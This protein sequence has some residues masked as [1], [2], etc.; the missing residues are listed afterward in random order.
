MPI[1]SDENRYRFLRLLADNPE[2]NQR[3]VANLL[4]ISLGKVNFC[5]RAL[6]DKGFI[7]ASNFR[8]SPNK[9]AYSYLLTPKGIEEKSIITYRFLKQ[10]QLDYEL[11][12]QEIKD[13]RK[14]SEQIT[15][16]E[17]IIE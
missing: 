10:K 5:I 11:L 15:S 12:K 8:H 1:I 4:G 3:Q 9:K 14:E 13:L 6:I 16:S 17:N 2:V 7:K